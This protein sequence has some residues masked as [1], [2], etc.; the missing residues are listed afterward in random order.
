MADEK[1]KTLGA[2][3][4]ARLLGIKPT[5]LRSILRSLS[6]YKE[7]DHARYEWLPDS[8]EIAK[9]KEVVAKRKENGRTRAK[10]EK[11]AKGKG[12]AKAKKASK[13][14]ADSKKSDAI[15]EEVT[16]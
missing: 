6:K 12:K 2:K 14:K 3:E 5:A 11:V 9:L 10:V 1:Q 13:G 4:V 16:A 7:N 15:I 8:P